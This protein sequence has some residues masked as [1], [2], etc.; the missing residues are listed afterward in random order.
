MYET[1]DPKTGKTEIDWT[2]RYVSTRPVPK[3]G[4]GSLICSG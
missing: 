4:G 2:G 1:T 3:A